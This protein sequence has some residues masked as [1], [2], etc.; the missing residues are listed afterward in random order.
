MLKVTRLESASLPYAVFISKVLLHFQ[1]NCVE[2]SCETYNKRNII[3]II[4]LHHMN[5]R[6][7]PDG[8]LFKDENQD[9]EEAPNGS[10]AASFR[11]KSEFEKYMV[12]QMHSLS[13][14]YTY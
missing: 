4:V 11:P 12:R 14:L 7:G 6:H 10:S 3:D 5:L 13:I 1:V 2:E 8:W 9:E